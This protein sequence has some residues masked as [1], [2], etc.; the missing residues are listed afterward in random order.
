MSQLNLGGKFVAKLASLV[1]TNSAVVNGDTPLAALGKL[2]AQIDSLGLTK[3]GVQYMQVQDQK[4]SGTAG[5]ASTAGANTR[6]L[7]TV[8]SNTITGASLAANVITL[9]AGTYRVHAES[10][11]VADTTAS[12][13]TPYLQNTADSVKAL[14]GLRSYTGVGMSVNPSVRG[15]YTIAAAK[16]FIFVNQYTAANANGLGLPSSFGYAE[17]YSNIEIWK[18]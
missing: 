5:G 7:N 2:Q 6:T 11:A 9:P 14:I 12:H 4:A 16:T 8:V 3:I 10:M 13:V 17:V 15:R 1:F 18:E